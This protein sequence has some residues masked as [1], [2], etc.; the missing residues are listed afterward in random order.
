MN[1]LHASD[2]LLAIPLEWVVRRFLGSSLFD[3][4]QV[5]L[6]MP[7]DILERDGMYAVV[8]DLPGLKKGD[9]HMRIGGKQVQIEVSGGQDKSAATNGDKVLRN[10]CNHAAISRTFSLADDIDDTRLKASSVAR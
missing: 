10:E 8:A 7:V 1:N 6:R 3:S 9:I 4:E 5:T 2:P